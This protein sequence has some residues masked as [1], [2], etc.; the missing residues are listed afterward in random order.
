MVRYFDKYPI[1]IKLSAGGDELYNYI[2]VNS[3]SGF[4]QSVPDYT[5]VSGGYGMFSS[6]IN[7]TKEVSLSSIAQTGLYGKESWGF[8]Q[9]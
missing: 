5:N 6:R 3:Q 2:Q 8:V 4:L 9:H 1:Q 7:L